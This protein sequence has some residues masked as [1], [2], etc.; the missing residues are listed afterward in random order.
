MR[1]KSLFVAIAVF[2]V[3]V[4]KESQADIALNGPGVAPGSQVATKVPFKNIV[5]VP[6]LY[7]FVF[8][9]IS[10]KGN[11]LGAP[12]SSG[13]E[14]NGGQFHVS[15]TVSMPDKIKTDKIEFRDIQDF[16]TSPWKYQML[17]TENTYRATTTPISVTIQWMGEGNAHKPDGIFSV[18]GASQPQPPV[19]TGSLDFSSGTWALAPMGS[20]YPD[21]VVKIVRE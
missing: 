1:T 18:L 12:G 5:T 15:A 11:T 16:N 20:Q 19:P 3:G 17:A 21:G 4:A 10:A 2:A 6:D 7:K 13:T 8:S 9:G 14:G